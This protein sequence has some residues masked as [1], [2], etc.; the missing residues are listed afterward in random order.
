MPSG[1]HLRCLPQVSDAVTRQQDELQGL[2]R[3]REQLQ[4]AEARL[5]ADQDQLGL[6]QQAVQAELAA[7]QRLREELLQQQKL[8][9]EQGGSSSA[10]LQEQLAHIQREAAAARQEATE[11]GLQL[12]QLKTE[13]AQSQLTTGSQVGSKPAG[14]LVHKPTSEVPPAVLHEWHI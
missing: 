6:R 9:A 5:R 8:L 4:A 10:L 2:R 13:V 11:R 14:L 12:Q 1:Q 3:Q 7:T